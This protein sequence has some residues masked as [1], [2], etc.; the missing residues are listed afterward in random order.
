MDEGRAISYEVLGEGVPVYGSDGGHVGSVRHVIAAEQLDIF[1][2][3]VISTADGALL[4]AA[5]AKI[6]TIHEAGVD[7]SVDSSSA[8][9]LPTPER[10]APNYDAEDSALAKGWHHW[11]RFATGRGDWKRER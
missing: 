4:F 10:G 6:E 2:G 7:L 3:I 5:A 11:V 1:H 8:A 9:E